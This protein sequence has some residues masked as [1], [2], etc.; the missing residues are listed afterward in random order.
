MV[1]KEINEVSRAIGA[2]QATVANLTTMWERNDR[3]ATDGRRRLYDK[4]DGLQ[5]TVNQLAG[6]VEF[7]AL[8]DDVT[9]LTAR[10]DHVTTEIAAMKPRL[11]SVNDTRQQDIGSKKV[12]ALVWGA[13]IGLAGTFA[14][15]ALKLIDLFWPPKHP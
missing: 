8:K 4:V 9:T 3:E 1:D 10:V 15:I 11:D 14:A 13:M 7:D 6:R 12:L 2:L 5:K